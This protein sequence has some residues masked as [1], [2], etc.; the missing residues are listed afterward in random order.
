MKPLHVS[1]RLLDDFL[2]L[3]ADN[4]RRNLETCAI[5]AGQLRNGA[6]AI[7]TLIVPKQEATSDS[8][9]ALA[10]EEIFA[11]QDERDL[12]SL[13]WIH[14]HPTQSCFMSSIDL[15]THCAYQTM[16]D[17]AVAIVMAPRD[18]GRKYGVFRLATPEGLRQLQ[19]CPRRGFHAHPPL[20]SGGA[21]YET[22]GHVYLD[23]GLPAAVVDLRG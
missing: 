22:C 18:A 20:P 17:E 19:E 7:T 10:E 23:E 16:M 21:L 11:A 3:A 15:H 6:F 12:F 9:S 8:C 2:R 13:G 1:L 4:T 5:L 14:T